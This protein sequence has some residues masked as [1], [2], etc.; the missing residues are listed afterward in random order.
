MTRLMAEMAE[1]RPVG[2]VHRGARLFARKV[3]GLGGPNCDQ[4]LLVSR[5][6]RHDAAVILHGVFQE[7]ENKATYGIL[8]AVRVRQAPAQE[9]VEE[10]S[11]CLADPTP[12]VHAILRR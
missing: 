10:M 11:L 2:F 3:I 7:V 5:Y 9:R 6:R 8:R 1:Q 4:A 12:P